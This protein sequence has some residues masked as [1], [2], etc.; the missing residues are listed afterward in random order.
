MNRTTIDWADATWNPVTGCRHGC[1][2]CY[3][4]ETTRRFGGHDAGEPA[5]T[6]G[7]L[8]VLDEPMQ[9]RRNDGRMVKAPFPFFFEPT[10]HRYRLEEP[11]H[12]NMPRNIFVCSMSDLFGK[13]VPTGWIVQVLDAC[14]AAPQHNYLFLTKNPGRYM[15]LDKLALL[16]RKGNFWYGSTTT[17]AGD[18]L[19]W[20]DK[21]NTFVSAEPLHGPLHAGGVL[22]TKWV[23]V[24]AETGSRKD[25]QRTLREWVMNLADECHEQ[26]VPI[27]MKEN[28][29]TEGVL[30]RGEIIQKRPAEMTF[31]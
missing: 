7:G 17:K 28:L 1:P 8:N 19:F 27:F 14:L 24:G 25:K 3:A 5:F 15:E 26:G 18:P 20:S 23:I 4:N 11:Q 6:A 29:V 21:H 30:T 22:E 31:Y 13:W 16:P 9:I 2:Y 10:F 12:A